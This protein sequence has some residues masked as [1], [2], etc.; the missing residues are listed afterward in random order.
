MPYG[1]AV[2]RLA[3]AVAVALALT[4]CGDDSGGGTDA[5]ASSTTSTTAVLEVSADCLDATSRVYEA[6]VP[7]GQIPLRLDEAAESC[8]SAEAFAAGIEEAGANHGGL[9]A[10]TVARRA[11]VLNVQASG[12]VDL[13]PP[14]PD[15]LGLG[16]TQLC[17]GLDT[18]IGN[19]QLDE[20]LEG[21]RMQADLAALE[22]DGQRSVVEND[23]FPAPT[24]VSLA[25]IE[26]AEAAGDRE[27]FVV[28]ADV[29]YEACVASGWGSQFSPTP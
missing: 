27:A 29:A 23:L 2:R 17:N 26:A 14:G 8:P 7:S 21:A 13:D 15:D 10:I 3:I 19:L 25:I 9:L 1:D 28:A 22:S 5:A 4:A 6:A 20:P 11:C 12:C 24:P 16:G 18:L